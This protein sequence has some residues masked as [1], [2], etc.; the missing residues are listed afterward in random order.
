MTARNVALGLDLIRISMLR[1][2][3]S[4]GDVKFMSI[5]R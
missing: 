2:F 3:K 4:P 1:R 5:N